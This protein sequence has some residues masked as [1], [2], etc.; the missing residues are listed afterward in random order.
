MAHEFHLFR[1]LNPISGKWAQTRY[2]ITNQTARERYG[3]GNYQRIEHARE[4]ITGN[5]EGTPGEKNIN[6][7][8][9]KEQS[10]APT[11]KRPV[12]T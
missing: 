2:K 4:A 1:V 7:F 6:R 12:T 11:Q 10:R 9:D 8:E 3:E 5:A